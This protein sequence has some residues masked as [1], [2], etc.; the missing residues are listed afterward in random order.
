MC[1]L[2]STGSRQHD[3]WI[4]AA[5]LKNGGPRY[6]VSRPGGKSK[7]IFFEGTNLKCH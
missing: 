2:G 6:R 3:R 1:S 5:D 7:E 4:K